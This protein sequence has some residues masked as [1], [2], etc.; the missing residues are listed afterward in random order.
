MAES[1]WTLKQIKARNMEINAL[2][3]N[4]RC[5]RIFIADTDSLIAHFGPEAP[6]SQFD[7]QTCEA[8]NS[9]LKIMLGFR[10]PDEDWDGESGIDLE[11]DDGSDDRHWD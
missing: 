4:E 11:P 3:T 8:C 10:N 1:A 6:L 2:C 7:G 9:P 5:G